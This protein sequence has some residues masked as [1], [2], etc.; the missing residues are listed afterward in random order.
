MA[1]I[2]VAAGMAC[3]VAEAGTT[4]VPGDS[5]NLQSV[6]ASAA[7][8]DII[9]VSPGTYV[10]NIDLNNKPITVIST[11]GPSVTSIQGTGGSTVRIGGPGAE[12]EGFTITGKMRV[13]GSGTL[14][15]GNI[16]D[17]SFQGGGAID[18]NVASPR[19][20][21]NIFRGYSTDMQWTS[22]VISFVNSSSPVIVNNIFENNRSRGVNLTLPYNN[23]P[24][25]ANNTF[26]GNDVAIRV[27]R[28]VNTSRFVFRNNVISGNGIGLEVDFGSEANNP[29]WYHNIVYG[30][31]TDYDVI[32]NQTGLAGNLSSDPMFVDIDAGNYDLQFGSPAIDTGAALDAPLVDYLGRPRPVDG[33]LDGTALFDMGA[34]EATP[35]PATLT[36]LLMGGLALVRRRKRRNCR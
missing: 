19:I 32:S 14:I 10:G 11:G 18:G 4:V 23:Y 34:F 31:S 22:G 1:V 2:V 29:T 7:P 9:L 25:V 15:R 21:A 27:D 8:G 5:V 26:V 24:I 12:I 17:G 28:R 36:L 33:D 30:N 20:E 13:Y 16:F 3:A 35:E 6:I